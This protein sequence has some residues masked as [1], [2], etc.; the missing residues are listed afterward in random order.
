MTSRAGNESITE[1]LLKR[2]PVTSVR[3][4]GE[5]LWR[6]TCSA[7]LGSVP[8]TDLSLPFTV[9]CDE[10]TGVA[11]FRHM[12]D[13]TIGAQNT[14]QAEKLLALIGRDENGITPEP[15]PDGSGLQLVY[16]LAFSGPG[17][18]PAVQPDFVV[19]ALVEALAVTGP[20]LH[21]VA[22]EG[23]D[24]DAALRSCPPA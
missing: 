13:F 18:Q 16:R 5:G 21:A 11:V 24:A 7:P 8:G 19:M 17:G 15:G 4:I 20:L 9:V 1:F 6:L 2:L 12:L 10:I 22:V 14:H 23:V 3:N